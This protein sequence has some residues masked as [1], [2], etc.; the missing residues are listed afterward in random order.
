[1]YTGGS[2]RSL[3]L[4][5]DAAVCVHV[6]FGGVESKFTLLAVDNVRAEHLLS[7]LPMRYKQLW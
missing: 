5:F 7:S 2:G 3:W 6:V 4:E 1:M